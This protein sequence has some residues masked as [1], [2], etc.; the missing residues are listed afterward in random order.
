MAKAAVRKDRV[1]AYLVA[2]M[3]RWVDGYD[4]ADPT[5]GGSEGLR[6][7][8]E[9]RKTGYPI[10]KQRKPGSAA[11]QYRMTSYVGA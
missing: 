8:R 1:F 10:E 2:N 7:L 4:L 5:V 3:D 9:L 11:F 6:R